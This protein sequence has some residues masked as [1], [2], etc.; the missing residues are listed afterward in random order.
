MGIVFGE[1]IEGEVKRTKHAKLF[2]R[3]VTPTRYANEFV[4]HNLGLIGSVNWIL[5]S[6]GMSHFC[7]LTS[8]TYV[9]LTYEFLS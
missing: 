7:T 3:E 4:L 8:P 9:R 2:S 5:G 1:G 6:L